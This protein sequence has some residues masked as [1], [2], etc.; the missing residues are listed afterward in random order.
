MD[1]LQKNMLKNEHNKT[2]LNEVL[3]KEPMNRFVLFPIKYH[4]IWEM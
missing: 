1:N 2:Q 3:L 4:D